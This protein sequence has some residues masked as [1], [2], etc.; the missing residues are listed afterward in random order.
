M[1]PSE[2]ARIFRVDPKTVSRWAARGV[3]PSTRTLGGHRRFRRSDVEA[4]LADEDQV[5]AEVREAEE[6]ERLHGRLV[7]FADWVI[8]LDRPEMAETRRNLTLPRVIDLARAA[9]RV[10]DE[11]VEP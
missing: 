6:R 10:G 1:T 9:R 8:S 7:G 2:V 4:L 11:R 3:L 5:A